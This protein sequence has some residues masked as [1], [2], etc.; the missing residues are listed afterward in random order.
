MQRDQK[1][2]TWLAGEVRD[3]KAGQ[4]EWLPVSLAGEVL[5]NA[6]TVGREQL[7]RGL[8]WIALLETL[9]SPT[10]GVLW[11]IIRDPV[12]VPARRRRKGRAPSPAAT[13]PRSP[14]S[15]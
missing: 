3:V 11:K 1:T 7:R 14:W 10:N 15:G 5:Q 8:G 12:I 6:V 9:R 13:L 2:R 4:H